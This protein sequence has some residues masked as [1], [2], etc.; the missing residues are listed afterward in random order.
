MTDKEPY[1]EAVMQ[2]DAAASAEGP[3]SEERYFSLMDTLDVVERA[4]K[5]IRL[6]EAGVAAKK[7]QV[8]ELVSRALGTK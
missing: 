1:L 2:L 5:G 6:E 4:V 3:Y 8:V 7:K